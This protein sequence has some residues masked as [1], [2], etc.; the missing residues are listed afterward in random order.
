MSEGALRGLL[1]MDAEAKPPGMDSR[2]PRKAPSDSG[3]AL[4]YAESESR[5]SLPLSPQHNLFRRVHKIALNKLHADLP[6]HRHRIRVFHAFS[7]RGDIPLRSRF[8]Q[9]A[10]TLLQI[11]IVRQALHERAVDLHEI[12]RQG[13]EQPL[14]ISPRS[15]ALE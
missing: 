12:Q 10:N 7:N 14:R 6:Q 15:E 1:R 13:C 8:N 2:R 4:H 11:L 5:S 3:V 9:Q